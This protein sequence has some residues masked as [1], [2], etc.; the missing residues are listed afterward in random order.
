MADISYID[1]TCIMDYQQT[2]FA[3]KFL[4]DSKS[5]N[6]DAKGCS[7]EEARMIL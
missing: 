5:S 4:I 1:G 7:D 3:D 2:D 6:A